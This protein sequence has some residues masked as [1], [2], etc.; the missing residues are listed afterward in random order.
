MASPHPLTAY[1]KA[2][3][4]SKAELARRLGVTRTAV[5]RWESGVRQPDKRFWPIIRKVTGL[6]PSEVAGFEAL[7]AAE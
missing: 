6:R 5:C 7:E 2:E 1:R 3:E 4:I